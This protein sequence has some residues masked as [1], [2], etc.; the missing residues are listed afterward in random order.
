MRTLLTYSAHAFSIG[1]PPLPNDHDG[2][3]CGAHR[4]RILHIRLR[5]HLTDTLDTPSGTMAA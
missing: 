3:S 1:Y 5:L 2:F 4:Y